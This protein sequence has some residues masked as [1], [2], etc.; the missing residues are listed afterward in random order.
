M[1]TP[2]LDTRRPQRGNQGFENSCTFGCFELLKGACLNFFPARCARHIF[3][4]IFFFARYARSGFEWFLHQNR[5]PKFFFARLRL[6]VL[7]LPN[8]L[9]FLQVAKRG[10]I[11]TLL[12]LN[13]PALG[14][15]GYIMFLERNRYLLSKLTE[16]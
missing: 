5:G 6:A 4:M 12:V 8:Y 1:T 9:I 10:L 15:N 14:C 2:H 3:L 7:K 16:T 13:A 11:S